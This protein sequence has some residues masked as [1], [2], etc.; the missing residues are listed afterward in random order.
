M[1]P[2]FE[3]YSQERLHFTEKNHFY[4]DFSKNVSKISI[5]LRA[6]SNKFSSLWVASSL[7]SKLEN[8]N[9]PTL[10]SRIQPSFIHGTISQADY[11]FTFP[12]QSQDRQIIHD[13]KAV[14]MIY[15]RYDQ[16]S[17]EGVSRWWLTELLSQL[18]ILSFTNMILPPSASLIVA[19]T[20][21]FLLP[22]IQA[23]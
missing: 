20:P 9:E 12:I 1:L 11:L 15:V 6:I 22:V 5:G 7:G 4:G 16:A 21:G 8:R 2:F 19:L 23:S 17:D 10:V 3:K 13:M 18:P 14:G